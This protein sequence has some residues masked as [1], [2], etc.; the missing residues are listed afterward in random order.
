M[1][2]R[3][4]N[5]RAEPMTGRSDFLVDRCCHRA[6]CRRSL[7]PSRGKG[8]TNQAEAVALAANHGETR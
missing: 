8:A 5:L 1:H 3:V 7:S 4:Q 6:L 2:P